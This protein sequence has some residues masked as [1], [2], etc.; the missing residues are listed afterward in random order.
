MMQSSGHKR[1]FAQICRKLQKALKKNSREFCLHLLGLREAAP[2]TKNAKYF[3]RHF[4][5]KSL[6]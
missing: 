6:N 5:L 4:E 3:T 1:F 2:T